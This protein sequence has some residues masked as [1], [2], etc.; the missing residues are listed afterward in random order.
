MFSRALTNR[1]VK[2]KFRD[3]DSKDECESDYLESDSITET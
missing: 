2:G 1:V 3:A